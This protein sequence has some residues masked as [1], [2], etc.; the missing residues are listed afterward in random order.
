MIKAI[1]DLAAS[2][3]GI[4]VYLLCSKYGVPED[5]AGKNLSIRMMVPWCNRAYKL[6]NKI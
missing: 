2:S 6:S 3:S 1:R 5:V 4:G